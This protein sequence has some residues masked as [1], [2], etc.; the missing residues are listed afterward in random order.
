[1][2]LSLYCRK[3]KR[4]IWEQSDPVRALGA[5]Q[6]EPIFDGLEMKLVDFKLLVLGRGVRK[7]Y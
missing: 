4:A 3:R 7:Y 6:L 5:E 2:P 1:M